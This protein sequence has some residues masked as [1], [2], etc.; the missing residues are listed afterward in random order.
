MIV[1]TLGQAKCQ[2]DI[3]DDVC[4]SV[5]SM[6]SMFWRRWFTSSAGAGA[7]MS[8]PSRAKSKKSP[9]LAGDMRRCLYVVPCSNIGESRSLDFTAGATALISKHVHEP[10]GASVGLPFQ[11]ASWLEPCVARAPLPARAPPVG[12]AAQSAGDE[13]TVMRALP[14]VREADAADGLYAL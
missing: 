13:R 2:K 5:E 12:M 11:L 9:F 6:A 14:D 7:A 3:T 8:K 4:I 10:C 1:R